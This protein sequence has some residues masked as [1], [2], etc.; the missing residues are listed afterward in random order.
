MRVEV[1]DSQHDEHG[2]Q[3]NDDPEHRQIDRVFDA[4]IT[5]SMNRMG[6]LMEQSDAN[7][8]TTHTTDDAL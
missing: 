7:N 6:H 4:A 1:E 3:A 2:H 8:E 5:Q